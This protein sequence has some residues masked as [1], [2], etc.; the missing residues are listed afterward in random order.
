[1]LCVALFVVL[2]V[3]YPLLS[4]GYVFMLDM[5]FSPALEI[6]SEVT[7]DFGLRIILHLVSL[8]VPS[9]MIQK[10]IL[11]SILYI[12]IASCFSLYK[13]LFNAAKDKHRFVYLLNSVFFIG[14]YI[15]NP[16]VY[17][18]FIT[19]QWL[20][21]LG[22]SLVPFFIATLLRFLENNT[23]RRATV[24]ML[25]LIAISIISIHTLGLLLIVSLPLIGL[26]CYRHW[27]DWSWYRIF[28]LQTLVILVIFI[29][30]N[31]YWLT[32]ALF[33]RGK[34]SVL[35]DGFGVSDFTAFATGGDILGVLGNVLTMQGFW[36]DT[37]N[38]YLTPQDVFSWWFIPFCLLA[39]LVLLGVYT[40]W[41][42]SRGLTIAFLMMFI[43]AVVLATGTSGSIFAPI[44]QWLVTHVPFFAGYR[45]PQKFVAI[46]VLTYAIFAS[47]GVYL[48]AEWIKTRTASRAL[49]TGFM[50]AV[51]MIPFACAPL[52]L[53][54]FGG[55]LHVSDYPKDWY[56]MNEYF[57]QKGVGGETKILALPWHMYMRF[58]FTERVIANP[59]D[60][61]FTPQLIVSDDPE[62]KGAHSYTNTDDQRII[63]KLL[64]EYMLNN[65]D[66]FANRL[67][68]QHIQYIL[69][70][71]EFDY[72]KYN[73]VK[74]QKGLS[75]MRDTSTLLLYKV[76]PDSME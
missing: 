2:I 74:D 50:I 75:I 21:L 60:H 5:V 30:A 55:Q 15:F 42:V 36:A 62:Y 68:A 61:F 63:K 6:P 1:M 16:F 18:R 12:S 9:Y 56:N 76:E 23:W 31:S 29:A 20:I 70:A 10:I 53:W 44:N 28:G 34:T 35:I 51:C 19:G 72:Q 3:L 52:M 73:Y 47:M 43:I 7:S 32:P 59:M 69:V 58:D 14:I 39:I 49:T 45:E 57:K 38:L 8:L 71:K 48:V 22:Y 25:C 24:L 40:S 33:G 26:Y 17:S 64:D 27:K 54:G 37:A 66:D 13:T 46:I 11:V 65:G 41:R 67:R 4:S